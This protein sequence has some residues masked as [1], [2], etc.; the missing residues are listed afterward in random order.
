MSLFSI[1][2]SAAGGHTWGWSTGSGNRDTWTDRPRARR[3]NWVKTGQRLSSPRKG[4]H[5]RPVQDTCLLKD[6]QAGNHGFWLAS[7]RDPQ[8]NFSCL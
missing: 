1:T 5:K 6:A 4:V 3:G 8:V 2:H 7:A